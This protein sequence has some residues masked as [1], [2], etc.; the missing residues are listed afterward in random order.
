MVNDMIYPD[1]MGGSGRYLREICQGLSSRGHV[2]HVMTRQWKPDQPKEERWGAVE[3][4]R[5]TVDAQNIISTILST[6][7]NTKV[8]F[9]RLA[10]ENKYDIINFHQPL[11]ALGIINSKRLRNSAKVYTFHSPWHKEYEIKTESSRSL[12]RGWH[13]QVRRKIEQAVLRKCSLAIVLSQYMENQLRETHEDLPIK[14]EQ[15]PGGADIH[16]FRPSHD[17]FHVRS[18][19]N[20]SRDK[21]LLLTVR[22]LTPR[23][24]VKN[25]IKAME[26]V[27]SKNNNIHLII[28]GGGILKKELEQLVKD[29]RL[30]DY[31]SFAGFIPEEKLVFYYQ[32]ADYFILP[33]KYLEG[34][35][36]V[37]TE[38]LSCGLPVLATPVGG[39]M[40]IL[41]H[42]DQDLLFEGTT[43]EA[44]AALILKYAQI[45]DAEWDALSC[46]CRVFIENNYSWENS[47]EK[48]EKV[49]LSLIA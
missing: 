20:L 5:Y 37:T 15:C 35:G 1:D 6:I 17:R 22:G 19:L 33:T 31:V 21:T 47:S 3:I 34:F 18:Q 23:T 30:G 40:E 42:F 46:R 24:G 26:G 49:F 48:T 7:K 2:V 12:L 39:T 9:H 29:L 41:N 45:K 28:G 44:M 36:L 13:I 10:K 4:Y 16:T 32:A 43:P 25:L 8:L 11:A 14:V 27:I 38:A